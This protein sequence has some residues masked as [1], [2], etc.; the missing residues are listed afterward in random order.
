M[1]R[2][3]SWLTV[4]RGFQPGGRK[5]RPE[6][7]ANFSESFAW[8]RLVRAA[9]SQPALAGTD[10]C[11]HIFKPALKLAALVCVMLGW[12]NL[13][14]A[15]LTNTVATNR[16][17]ALQV[18]DYGAQ[19]DFSL[20]QSN[21]LQQ[22]KRD[23]ETAREDL[24]RVTGGDD[25]PDVQQSARQSYA[26]KFR[27]VN[28]RIAELLTDEQKQQLTKLRSSVR[29]VARAAMNTTASVARE[30]DSEEVEP[31][32]TRLPPRAALTSEQYHELAAQLRAAYAKPSAQWPAPTLDAEVKPRFVELGLLPP[33][34]YPTNNL[35][36]EAKA[37]LGKKLFFDPRLS[38][39]GQ[40]ACASCHDPELG[41]GDGRAVAFGH[42]RK[43]TKRNAP[44]LV[45]VGQH[46]TLFWDGRAA[47][48]EAQARDVLLNE[49]EMRGDLPA[50]E[51]RLGAMAGYTNEFAAAFGSPEVT[52]TRIVRALATFERTI[53]S[54][55]N[56]FDSFVR[57]N[58]NALGDE[59]VRG[60]HLFRTTAR[61]ANCHFG[62]T[63]S[64]ELFH[65]AGLSY[66]GRKLQDLGRHDVTQAAADVGAFKTPT[67]RNLP[68]TAPYMHNGLFDLTGVLNLYNA[69]MPTLRRKPEQKD[70]PKFP[71][72]SALLK[73]LALNRQDLA[74]LKAFLESL[75]ETRLRVRPPEL[76]EK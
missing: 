3:P 47:S 36:S 44:T 52:A 69:G 7:C 2:Q 61:C 38:G 13:L 25:P 60:L 6:P 1:W 21:T 42:G 15:Q 70:D 29:P 35:Y 55:A 11:R 58:T 9:G 53:V 26:E 34:P 17:A 64:D 75:E 23:Y 4:S 66:Y 63:F 41:W 51:A 5:P 74:D 33:V 49:D 19:L 8:L 73:P 27:A 68:R 32:V 22:L 67:L 37:E 46:K 20:E 30:N 72:K 54:R 56:A 31:A 16:P 24:R 12:T 18:W 14:P 65:N 40:I 43:A 45:N 28:R 57:G 62:P 10:A 76:P 50:I 39:S 71:V 59:A 48:L